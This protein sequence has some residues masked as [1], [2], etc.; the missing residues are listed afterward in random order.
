M[1]EF[2][3]ASVII[4]VVDQKILSVPSIGTNGTAQD[5]TNCAIQHS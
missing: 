1:V 5:V 4:I 3:I 2:R